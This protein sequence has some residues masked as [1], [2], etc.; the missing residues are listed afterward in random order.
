MA[1]DTSVFSGG[2]L[3]NIAIKANM[4]DLDLKTDDFENQ[5]Y[6][7]LYNV[8]DLY[9]EFVNKPN[10]EYEI[11]L[12]RRS[13]TN[14]T[15]IVD[16]IY[17]FRQDISHETALKLNPYIKDEA[18]EMEK[19]DEEGLSKYSMQEPLNISKGEEEE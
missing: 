4:M 2:S 13:L 14:D 6:D 19:I 11:E 7:F 9:L 12:I 16:N 18:R 5:V 15:E 17:K 3:T 10:E 8:I 1:L